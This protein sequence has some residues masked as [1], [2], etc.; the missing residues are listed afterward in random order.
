MGVLIFY[1]CAKCNKKLGTQD[2]YDSIGVPFVICQACGGSNIIAKNRTEW[3]LKTTWEKIEMYFQAS[4]AVVA[5]GAG[6][7]MVVYLAGTFLMHYFG[8][9]ALPK[10]V[11][12]PIVGGIA[13]IALPI[14]YVH[15]FRD[16]RKSIAASHERMRDPGYIKQLRDLNLIM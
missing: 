3:A 4:F 9:Y 12:V 7:A 8:N 6:G 13:V 1:K 11:D 16:L 5:V 14:A 10:M 15:F 2:A